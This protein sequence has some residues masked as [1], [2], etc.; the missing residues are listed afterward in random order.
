M[1]PLGGKLGRFRKHDLGGLAHAFLNM[2]VFD[3]PLSPEAAKER[4]R[5]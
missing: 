3:K 5:G 4:Y 2:I 1:I